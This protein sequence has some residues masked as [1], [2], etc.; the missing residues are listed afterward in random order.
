MCRQNK[1]TDKK[2]RENRKCEK[3]GNSWESSAADLCFF[4]V[5][6]M[7]IYD[8]KEFDFCVL[9]YY[10]KILFSANKATA[11]KWN[12][13]KQLRKKIEFT[14]GS[15][16]FHTWNMF[17]WIFLVLQKCFWMNKKAFL[18]MKIYRA[19]FLCFFCQLNFSSWRIFNFLS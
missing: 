2:K 7:K 8:T 18:F 10:S 5:P 11:T 1:K 9:F 6:R 17:E 4:V 12:H 14:F 16:K 15:I 3:K 13:W 19:L